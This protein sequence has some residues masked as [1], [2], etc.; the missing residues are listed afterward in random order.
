[1]RIFSFIAISVTLLAACSSPSSPTPTTNPSASTS[2]A[3]SASPTSTSGKVWTD[4]EFDATQA[5]FAAS[6]NQAAQLGAASAQTQI[7]ALRGVRTTLG[8]EAYQAKLNQQGD[9]FVRLE[10]QLKL[11]CVK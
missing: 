7:T 1:M 10:A 8:P 4:A 6:S 5:C 2:P 11:G 3:A 9:F